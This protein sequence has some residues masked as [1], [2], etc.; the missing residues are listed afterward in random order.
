VTGSVTNFLHQQIHDNVVYTLRISFREQF[1]S[2]IRLAQFERKS[3]VAQVA[4]CGNFRV[5]CVRV[6]A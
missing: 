1:H 4:V 3:P 6:F 5:V 2:T